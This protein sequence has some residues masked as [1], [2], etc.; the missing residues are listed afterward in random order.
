MMKFKE[1]YLFIL[2]SLILIIISL[3]P[4]I[5]N[6]NNTLYFLISYSLLLGTYFFIIKKDIEY[7]FQSII[8]IYVITRI[9]IIPMYAWLS[10]DVFTYLWQGKLVYNGINIYNY[11]P[12]DNQLVNYRDNNW[13][14]MGNITI[15]AIYPP[16]AT[17]IFA[18]N[19]K[20]ANIFGSN[21]I[22]QFYSW[23]MILIIG[24]LLSI[25]LIK[26]N[27]KI[28]NYNLLIYIL[29]P[30]CLIEIIGQGHNDGL[31]I[32]II[33]LLIIAIYQSRNI[34]INSALIAIGA[35]IK[36]TPIFLL[37][38]LFFRKFDKKII[39]SI[40]AS[41]FAILLV[42]IMSY[43]ILNSKSALNNYNYGMSYFNFKAIF[44]SAP[45][46]IVKFT[47]NILNID[48][49][50]QK[51]PYIVYYSKLALIAII[52]I[53]YIYKKKDY[54]LE[55]IT[56]VLAVAYLISTKVHTWYF[57]PIIFLLSIMMKKNYIFGLSIFMLSYYVYLFPSFT[58]YPLLD[59]TIWVVAIAIS[60]YSKEKNV[61]ID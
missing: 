15:P 51:A 12:L 54:Q 28:K 32:P 25:L 44:F 21:E 42:I 37:P 5:R 8:I 35:L 30:L 61:G 18:L 50:W 31:L 60:Y 10:D 46:E 27:T 22:I 24:E 20:I 6:P 39:V 48:N 13:L 45:L 29:N 53:F 52:S 23:K 43:P 41:I 55:F 9:I 3:I 16:I 17:Y 4:P 34:F 11:F 36:M 26:I 47:L 38:I 59:I 58:Y 57:A 40:V 14:M 1:Y 7:S 19:Y 33:T 49:Y 2:Y 56:L